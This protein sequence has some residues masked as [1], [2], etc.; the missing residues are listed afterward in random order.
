MSELIGFIDQARTSL[1][2]LDDLLRK[3]R[4]LDGLPL[5][6]QAFQR[7]GIQKHFEEIIRM[8]ELLPD[9]LGI[10]EKI[11]Q[12]N[13]LEEIL[14]GIEE[15]R[16]QAEDSLGQV[17][18]AVEKNLQLLREAITSLSSSQAPAKSI[19]A[20][21]Q[22]TLS[23]K[24]TIELGRSHFENKD[25]E[26]CI[27]LLQE[28]SKN[29]PLNEEARDFLSE[30][31]Q[32]W[33]DQRLEEELVIHIENLKREA[34]EFFDQER[35]EE[36]VGMFRFLC[37]LEPQNRTLRDY[38]ELSQQKAQEMADRREESAVKVP[39]ENLTLSG[40]VEQGSGPEPDG[41]LRGNGLRKLSIAASGNSKLEKE[42]L[43]MAVLS[44]QAQ[45]ELQAG[46]IETQDRAEETERPAISSLKG[47]FKNKA[48]LLGLLLVLLFVGGVVTLNVL[49]HPKLIT[50][51]V[52]ADSVPSGAD[53]LMDGEHKGQ[54]PLLLEGISFG[55]HLIQIDKQGY[56]SFSRKIQVGNEQPVSIM[57]QLEKI[58]VQSE[59]EPPPD[60]DPAALYKE[61]KTE[62]AIQ[63]CDAILARDPENRTALGLKEEIRRTLLKESR[64][65]VEKARWDE[66]RA[67]LRQV[68]IVAP[69]N[70]EAL[71]ELKIIKT[72][73]KKSSTVPDPVNNSESMRSQELRQALLQAVNSGNYF[74][75]KSGNAMDVISQ[76]N[77]LLP[78]DPVVKEKLDLIYRE[79]LG[80]TQRRIQSR[81]FEGARSM[82]K[83]LQT[84]FPDRAD[85]KSLR[86]VLN[87]EEG[88]AQ[89]ARE[90][91]YQ[92]AESAMAAGHY[93]TP[94]NENAVTYCNRALG[95]D[96]Q[97]A[98]LLALKKDA[99]NKAIG[100]AKELI[101]GEKYEEARAV[102]Q[103][104]APLSLGEDSFPLSARELSEAIQKLE[105]AAFPVVH[106]HTI[107]N[108]T[109]RLRINGYVIAFVPSGDAKDAFS[110]P[111]REI[112]QVETGDKLK[113]QFKT[114]T[115][116]FQ[117]NSA[118][119]KEDNREKLSSID[120]K[121]N[122][123]REGNK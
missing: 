106:D 12:K 117:S 107:G 56:V 19:P 43:S 6:S 42:R 7:E 112:I 31:Q 102:Y 53:I 122:Q 23:L 9:N 74:P 11:S 79:V 17:A 50:N 16:K 57:A 90:T 10:E 96:P 32:K 33:E 5:A 47:T 71:A 123:V 76:L 38:L 105:F 44:D 70:P 118:T 54:T 97:N 29:E 37:E 114:R 119:S 115:F 99:L 100:Q 87:S 58:P 95:A 60:V 94:V 62:E 2:Q 77:V 34:T 3:A 14:T 93:V 78:N 52:M 84:Y 26:A 63:A 25:Y 30:A 40:S 75:P 24:E 72:K 83:T 101:R 68:L 51:T 46:S 85:V 120:R 36:C 121:L 55:S 35:F 22:G 39:H 41:I 61:G 104:L 21:K 59:P 49:R 86:E 81:D 69:N 4:S 110:Q 91:S 109:G 64:R 88:R 82:A 1:Q 111:L 13:E 108:C 80:Q 116:R 28:A 67:V 92:K 103:A 8:V 89:T 45:N 15:V 65:L 20:P 98:K 66:A 48:L 27:K 73:Q 113:I 18:A